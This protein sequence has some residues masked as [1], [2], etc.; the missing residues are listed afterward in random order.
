M[1]RHLVDRERRLDLDSPESLAESSA[2]SRKPEARRW[3]KYRWVVLQSTMNKCFNVCA[4]DALRIDCLYNE[5]R[6][7]TDAARGGGAS[8]SRNHPSASVS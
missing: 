8:G 5:R 2:E 6:R 4:R 3:I 7:V 1:W